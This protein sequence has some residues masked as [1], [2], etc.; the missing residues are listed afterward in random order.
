MMRIIKQRVRRGNTYT[1][2]LFHNKLHKF[3]KFLQLLYPARQNRPS[4]PSRK[5]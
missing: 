3:T 4:E 1:V 5:N 2:V